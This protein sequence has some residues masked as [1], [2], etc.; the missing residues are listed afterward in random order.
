MRVRGRVLTPARRGRGRLA[1]AA[2]L[3][4]LTAACTV[5]GADLTDAR[6][7]TLRA[8]NGLLAA[9]QLFEP[10]PSA[11]QTVY[12]MLLE[13]T[14]SGETT[15][16][17]GW[18]DATATAALVREQA[19]GVDRVWLLHLA[20]TFYRQPLLTQPDV[21]ELSV[22]VDQSGG[23][24]QN[25]STLGAT[26]AD[27]VAAATL[28]AYLATAGSDLRTPGVDAA[29]AAVT[30]WPASL[31]AEA[32]RVASGR[33]A[34]P[35][36]ADTTGL[37]RTYF[38]ALAGRD[39][40]HAAVAE[41]LARFET[42]AI[43]GDE[44]G[45]LW[46]LGETVRRG[47][48]DDTTHARLRSVI[49]IVNARPRMATGF[50]A[51]PRTVTGDPISTFV[52]LT[53]AAGRGFDVTDARLTDAFDEA[54]ASAGADPWEDAALAVAASFARTGSPADAV[55]AVRLPVLSAG[56]GAP[57][58]AGDRNVV[59]MALLTRQTAGQPG[60]VA[61]A[62]PSSTADSARAAVATWLLAGSA[63]PWA[64]DRLDGWL[65]ALRA[66]PR[67]NDERFLLVAALLSGPLAGGPRAE[68]RH[69]LDTAVA[70]ESAC[71]AVPWLVRLGPEVP[72]CDLRTSLSAT[73]AYVAADDARL[74][75][76]ID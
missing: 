36:T 62:E 65:A 72:E 57:A 13:L 67:S 55:G 52:A 35:G 1:A 10:R 24:V 20:G 73:I 61:I 76:L 28:K 74:P 48:F 25:A 45:L 9:P 27:E 14:A 34:S 7:D 66:E 43:S 39:V 75:Q 69:I 6:L 64:A 33:L 3:V 47:D 23:I 16:L 38:S 22:L 31:P 71:N 18:P 53:A 63:P 40:P 26:S 17:A 4:A 21:D 58:G 19:A 32:L 37:P 15:R 2:L 54:A 59:I 51:S 30:A 70:S 41:W 11:E 49:G 68:V 50:Y 46:L 44:A 29:V 56:T 12:R 5:R 42:G 8:D 60:P